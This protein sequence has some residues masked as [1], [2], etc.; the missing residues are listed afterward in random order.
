MEY[1]V[2]QVLQEAARTVQQ[3]AKMEVE[4][5]CE[6]GKWSADALRGEH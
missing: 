4:E 2:K 5:N 3:R 6:I 1:W